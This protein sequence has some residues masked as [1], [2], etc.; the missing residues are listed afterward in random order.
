MTL[1]NY[2]WWQMMKRKESLV[3]AWAITWIRTT[4]CGTL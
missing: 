1:L 3:F 2:S 4:R